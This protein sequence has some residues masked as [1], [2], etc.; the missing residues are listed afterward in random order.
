MVSFGSGAS[1]DTLMALT[2]TEAILERQKRAPQ[3]QDYISRRTV[4]DYAMYA[5]M[6]G[7]LTMK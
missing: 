2:V 6:R 7:K 1:S 3:T 4:I 5:R